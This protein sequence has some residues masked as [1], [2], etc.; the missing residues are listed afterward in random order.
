MKLFVVLKNGSA[1]KFVNSEGAP[2][3]LL[4]EYEKT[5]DV[6]LMIIGAQILNV[7]D[8]EEIARYAAECMKKDYPT[9][10]FS[11]AE[12]HMVTSKIEWS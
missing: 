1:D 6:T 11:V 4:E 10:R 7:F 8:D 3:E 9:D 5:K 12:L 2:R